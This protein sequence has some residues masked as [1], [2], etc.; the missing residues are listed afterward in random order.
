MIKR[1]IEDVQLDINN[2]TNE[3]KVLEQIKIKKENHYKLKHLKCGYEFIT[4]LSNFK[5]RYSCPKCVGRIF[6]KDSNYFNNEIKLI[7]NNYELKSDYQDCHTKVIIKHLI[8]GYEYPVTP[9]R[10]LSGDRCPKCSNRISKT[11]ESFKKEVFNLVK[12]DYEVLDDYPENNKINIKFKHNKC[13]SVFKMSPHNFLRGQRCPECY[14]KELS[15]KANFIFNLLK[16]N[17][18]KVKKEKTFDNCK[19]KA[20]LKFDF[21][22]DD[23]NCIIEF[24]GLQHFDEKSF[25][26]KSYKTLHKHDLMKNE[27]CK[28]KSINLIRIPYTLKENEIKKIII[29]LIK[30]K[31]LNKYIE[32][33][34]LLTVINKDIT[35][36]EEYYNKYTIKK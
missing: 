33:Y 12:N 26:G 4:K 3:F 5:R 23:Y 35:N 28:N 31:D 6:N 13:N 9:T 29:D 30:E 32:K 14:R 1:S 18:I 25:M 11:T 22:L 2:K 16:E 36:F 27:Y 21:M 24:D 7:D 17:K 19:D 10:F 15:K 20:L 34:S 8:C